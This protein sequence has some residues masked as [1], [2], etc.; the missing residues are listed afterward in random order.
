MSMPEGRKRIGER[1]KYLEG[2]RTPKKNGYGTL[3]ASGTNLE[4]YVPV[5]GQGQSDCLP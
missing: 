5:S 3:R 2:H 1:A 4:N